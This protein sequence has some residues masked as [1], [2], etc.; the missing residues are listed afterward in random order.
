MKAVKDIRFTNI[1]DET[2]S[3]FVDAF[4]E[5]KREFDN[6]IKGGWEESL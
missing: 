3:Y 1:D 4:D 2:V 5:F 6:E